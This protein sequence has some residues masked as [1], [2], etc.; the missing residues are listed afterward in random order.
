MW[1]PEMWSSKRVPWLSWNRGEKMTRCQLRRLLW[2]PQVEPRL[3][4]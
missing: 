3:F 4:H 2:G 1:L